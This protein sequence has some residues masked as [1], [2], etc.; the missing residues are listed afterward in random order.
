MGYLS[1]SE[2]ENWRKRVAF[3]EGESQFLASFSKGSNVLCI[4]VKASTLHEIRGKISHASDQKWQAICHNNF[5]IYI[6]FK[7]TWFLIDNFCHLFLTDVNFLSGK[8]G[9]LMLEILYND[10]N[11][12]FFL[13]ILILGWCDFHEFSK[14]LNGS[15]LK[16]N[17]G[18]LWPR[19][20][21]FRS[22]FQTF[23]LWL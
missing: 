2:L 6:F 19:S 11:F 8:C 10:L 18:I 13:S 1:D 22:K 23:P 3:C 15:R 17:F 12:E 7:I 9:K 4:I 21:N 20:Q 16:W 5:T 14:Y